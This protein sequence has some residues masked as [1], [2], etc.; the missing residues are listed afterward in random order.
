[1]PM[2]LSLQNSTMVSFILSTT[3]SGSEIPPRRD[4]AKRQLLGLYSN[5]SFA[6]ILKALQVLIFTACGGTSLGPPKIVP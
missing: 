6:K 3:F 2:F 5:F 4:A 1:M